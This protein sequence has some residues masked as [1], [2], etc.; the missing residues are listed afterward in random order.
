MYSKD[1]LE[2]KRDAY[3]NPDMNYY[4]DEAKRMRSEAIHELAADAAAGFRRQWQ[5]LARAL[6][7]GGRLPSVNH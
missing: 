5:Q 7:L 2:V 3:G 6:H 1:E 4:I